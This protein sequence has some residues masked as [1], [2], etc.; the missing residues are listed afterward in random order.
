M[1]KLPL[2][3]NQ[4]YSF[5]KKAVGATYAGGGKE[6]KKS[7]RPGFREHRYSEGNLSY[8]DSYTG[9]YRSR[10]TETVRYKNIPIWI[11]LYGGGM[12]KGKNDLAIKTFDFLKRAL[13]AKEE[14]FQ[15]FRGPNLFEEGS[16]KHTYSQEGDI[17]EFSG[18]QEIFYRGD[19]IFFHR[20][21]GGIV[22]DK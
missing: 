18:Y 12:I 13:G 5:I 16:W 9:F 15:S 11:S 22:E 8:L 3:K 2:N 19:L 21:I 20:L 10:G 4:L 7:E 14:G 6:E 17:L 1:N